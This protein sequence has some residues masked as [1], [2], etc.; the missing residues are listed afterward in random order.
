MHRYFLVRNL[1]A[2]FA[3][4]FCLDIYGAHC[5]HAHSDCHLLFLQISTKIPLPNFISKHKPI[6]VDRALYPRPGLALSN[7]PA[8]CLFSLRQCV[9]RGAHIF[10]H[11]MKSWV[12]ACGNWQQS[13]FGSG[14]R[15]VCLNLWSDRA[16]CLFHYAIA[17]PDTNFFKPETFLN[18]NLQHGVYLV[19]RRRVVLF[20]LQLKQPCRTNC[21]CCATCWPTTTRLRDPWRT[22][23]T[24]SRWKW[25]SRWT[26]FESW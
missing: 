18:L 4:F 14:W 25:A 16:P 2:K 23:R 15:F 20:L 1:R 21:D 6:H 19:H 7:R 5:P 8:M 26:R 24:R 3:D 17:W 11:L 22:S 13:G 10:Y 12:A 9:A